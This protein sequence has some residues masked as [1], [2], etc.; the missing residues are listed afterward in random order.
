M[1][2]VVTSL[3]ELAVGIPLVRTGAFNMAIG[4]LLGSNIFNIAII[5]VADIFFTK[6][7][8]LAN[9]SRDHVLTAVL[10]IVMT[11]IVIMDLI[12]RAKKVPWRIGWGSISIIILYFLGR[13]TLFKLGI[14]WREPSQGGILNLGLSALTRI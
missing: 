1:L 4:N 6:G 2:A 13:I 3:P 7:A 5:P 8:I 12:Y 11:N 9:V 14:R 10:G